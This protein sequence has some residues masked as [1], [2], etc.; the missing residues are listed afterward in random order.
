MGKTDSGRKLLVEEQT[1]LE[2]FD[3]LI[4]KHR[5]EFAVILGSEYIGCY[6][7]R[8]EAEKV[9]RK[10]YG[11]VGCLVKRISEEERDMIGKNEE[12]IF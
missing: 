3:S 1:Y 6:K 2:K 11:S 10:N 12:P 7:T 8:M 4:K 9:I 5:G